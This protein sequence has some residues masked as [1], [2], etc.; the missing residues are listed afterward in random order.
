[1]RH[2]SAD[3]PLAALLRKIHRLFIAAEKPLVAIPL[4]ALEHIVNIGATPLVLAEPLPIFPVIHPVIHS[5]VNRGAAGGSDTKDDTMTGILA[6]LAFLAAAILAVVTMA[7]TVLRYR[8]S[9]LANLAAHRDIA[10]TRDFHF[11]V[12]EFGRQPVSVGKVR[13]IAQRA[14]KRRPV[15]PAGWRAAA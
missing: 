9:V 8:D 5:A 4:D 2:R 13:R 3:A 7:G 10:E 14:A 11:R 12:F 15:M 1:M 6:S